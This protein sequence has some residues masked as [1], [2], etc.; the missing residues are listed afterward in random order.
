MCVAIIVKN[1]IFFDKLLQLKFYIRTEGSMESL[2]HDL[3][4]TWRFI[5]DAF[6]T[7]VA[8]YFQNSICLSSPSSANVFKEMC[9]PNDDLS[10]DAAQG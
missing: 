1:G 8:I 4:W 2:F 3:S 9:Q 5:G 6:L 7:Q 10:I